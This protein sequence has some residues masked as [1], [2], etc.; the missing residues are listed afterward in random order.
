VKDKLSGHPPMVQAYSNEGVFVALLEN[1]EVVT[2][3]DVTKGGDSSHIRKQ[4]NK[5]K[6][7]HIYTTERAFAAVIEG[8]GVITWGHPDFGGDSSKLKKRLNSSV[9]VRQIFSTRGAFAA[10]MDA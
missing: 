1:G 7:K 8:G 6:I 10:V 5:A 3:G 9:P 2:W 4:L